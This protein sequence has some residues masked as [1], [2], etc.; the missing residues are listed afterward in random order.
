MSPSG[1]SGTTQSKP[2]QVKTVWTWAR[3][4]SKQAEQRKTFSFVGDIEIDR[5]LVV[6]DSVDFYLN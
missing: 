1:K 5:Y 4:S 6:L 3:N 2:E